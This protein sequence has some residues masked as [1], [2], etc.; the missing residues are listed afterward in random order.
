MEKIKLLLVDDS[1]IHLEGLKTLLRPYQ[2][3][4]IQGEAFN[5]SEAKSLLKQQV[6]DLVLL[7][8]SLEE[9]A[10]GLDFARYLYQTFPEI[11]VIILS[12]YKEVHF[13]VE[14]LKAHVRA[15][16]AK[17][18]K[19]ADLVHAIKSVMG[20]KGLFFGDTLPYRALVDAFGGETYL[21]RGKPHGLSGQEIKVIQLLAEGNSS[22]QISE[23]L[24]IDK[25]TVESYKERIKVKL[26]CDT[27]VE[28]VVHAIRNKIIIAN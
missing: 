21:K 4:E 17:D 7:D 3:L 19:S 6:P 14:A 25:T 10:D 2:E 5:V 26:G 16:L 9:E 22:K 13:I 24:H 12:H 18:T 23:I 27:V 20:G 1:E 11:A 15:Y 8:I 28:I